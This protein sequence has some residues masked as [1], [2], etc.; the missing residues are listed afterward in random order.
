MFMS[1]LFL[2]LVGI[3]LGDSASLPVPKKDDVGV[4]Y[5]CV[6]NGTIALTFGIVR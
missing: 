3:K 2:F 4:Q 5:R 1:A 6:Q